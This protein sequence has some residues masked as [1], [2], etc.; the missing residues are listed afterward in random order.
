MYYD[1]RINSSPT[2]HTKTNKT[3]Q[4]KA[5]IEKTIIYQEA[6]DTSICQYNSKSTEYCLT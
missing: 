4:K 2:F 5:H 3:K 1:K 6:G